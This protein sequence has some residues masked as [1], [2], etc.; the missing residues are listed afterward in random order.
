MKTDWRASEF[1]KTVAVKVPID[2]VVSPQYVDHGMK[3]TWM[4]MWD[5]SSFKVK[6]TKSAIGSMMRVLFDG[7]IE[8]YNPNRIEKYFNENK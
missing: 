6:Y 4:W 7:T 8:Y 1:Q 2:K 3:S 5:Y